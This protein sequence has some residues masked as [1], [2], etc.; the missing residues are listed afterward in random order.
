LHQV[1]TSFLLA[2]YSFTVHIT[3]FILCNVERR[4]ERKT[5]L[6]CMR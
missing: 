6:K 5:E 4:T 2:I 1:G 3:N